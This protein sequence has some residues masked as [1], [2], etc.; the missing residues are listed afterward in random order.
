M[1][2]ETDYSA[3]KK[4]AEVELENVLKLDDAH[5]I[6][7]APERDEDDDPLLHVCAQAVAMC[8]GAAPTE[9]SSASGANG[10]ASVLNPPPAPKAP[11]ED[12]LPETQPAEQ[13][14]AGAAEQPAAKKK[15]A[16]KKAAAPVAEQPAK[17]KATGKK[18]AK[19]KSA[20]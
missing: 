18:E 4:E 15:T 2:D 12:T 17:A 11:A 19:A 9:K 13:A 3:L 14:A 10:A 5:Q 1:V 7:H 8:S 6:A 20:A 16:A